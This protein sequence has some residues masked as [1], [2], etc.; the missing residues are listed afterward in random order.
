MN[1]Y[2]IHSHRYFT[3]KSANSPPQNPLIHHHHLRAKNINLY[4]RFISYK[5]KKDKQKIDNI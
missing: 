5:F 3:T 1:T 4:N 2:T